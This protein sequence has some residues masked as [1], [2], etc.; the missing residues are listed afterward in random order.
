MDEL[1]PLYLRLIGERKPMGV[2]LEDADG[3]TLAGFYKRPG[4]G[5]LGRYNGGGT[6]PEIPPEELGRV[7]VP[8]GRASLTGFR[9]RPL[10]PAERNILAAKI[11]TAEILERLPEGLPDVGHLTADETID[12]FKALS[13]C[14]LIICIAAQVQLQRHGLV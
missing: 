7:T 11:K 14:N 6:L 3:N 12:A 5:Q 13:A 9:L 10:S 2:H 1:P 4:G 8:G